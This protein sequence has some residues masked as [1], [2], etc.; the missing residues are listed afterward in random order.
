MDYVLNK[1]AAK[2]LLIRMTAFKIFV[3]VQIKSV[4]S[5]LSKHDKSPPKT[6]ELFVTFDT[7]DPVS[8]F[9][10]VQ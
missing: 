5:L 10:A 9:T 2:L 3:F 6:A 4:N 1:T 8:E 7:E